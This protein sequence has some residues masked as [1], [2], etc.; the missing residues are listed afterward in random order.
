MKLE[1]F[2]LERLQSL[3]EHTVAWNLAESGVHPLRVEELLESEEDRLALMRQPLGYSQTNGTLDLRASIAAM[4]PGAGPSH[5]LVTNGGSEANLVVLTALVRPDDEVVAMTPNYM[6]VA[7]LARGLGAT[8]RS[9]K[10]VEDDGR[11]DGQAPRWRPD[12]EALEA[13]VGAKTRVIL[14]CNPNN[15]TGA[16]LDARELDEICRIASRVGA[17]VVSDEIYRGAE[18]DGSDSPTIWGRHDRCIVTAGLSKAY[19]L[20]GL[21]IGWVVAAP[22]FIDELWGIHDYTT[23]APGTINDLLARVALAP[24]RRA[25]L[26]ARTRG[27]LRTNYAI[28]RRWI[29]RRGRFLRHIPPEAGGIAFVRYD[30]PIGSTALVERVRDEQSV[31]VVPGDHF[32]MD[33]YLRFGYG[34][35]PE[36]LIG[37]L[38][39]IGVVLDAIASSPD[40]VIDS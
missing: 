37:G 6:Q 36:L 3:W 2:A 10:L 25:L 19:A 34:C 23:I 40:G 22:A 9:W 29:D 32:E 13:M 12:I 28:L 8:V 15:P 21:R 7:G 11:P 20:P 17:W 24:A 14:L 18:L 26:L 5:V 16:R 1:P 33:G 30:Y 35:D 4:Y 31:L 39:R 38:D 27:M